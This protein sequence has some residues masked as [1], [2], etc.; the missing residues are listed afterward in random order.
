MQPRLFHVF[1]CMRPSE[2]TDLL[3]FPADLALILLHSDIRVYTFAAD[4][5]KVAVA[6]IGLLVL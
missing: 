4:Q 1:Q 2:E 6:A 5:L 3:P